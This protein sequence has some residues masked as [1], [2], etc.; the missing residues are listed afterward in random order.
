[1]HNNGCAEVDEFLDYEIHVSEGGDS[2][3]AFKTGKYDDLGCALGL[4]VWLGAE[5][6]ARGP[7]I[8]KITRQN[9]LLSTAA[10]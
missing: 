3:T 1:M 8:W 7:L 9:S 6:R 5:F 10:P 2:Y 4:A